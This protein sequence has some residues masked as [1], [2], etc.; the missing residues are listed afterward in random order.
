MPKLARQECFIDWKNSEAKTVLLKDLHEGVLPLEEHDVS[1]EDAW[2]TCYVN[3]PEFANVNFDQFKRQLK[4]HRKQVKEKKQGADSQEAALLHDRLLYPEK[5]HYTIGRRIF[6]M[7]PAAP[8]LQADVQN[9]HHHQLT[10]SALKAS[11]PEYGEWE[12]KIFT[13]RIYQAERRVK[14]INYL[15]WKRQ[16][17]VDANRKDDDSAED[18][19]VKK[20]KHT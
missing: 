13:Q 15:E 4:A 17:K 3:L 16:Q 11:R 20:V 1:A 9:G 8:L 2:N 10:P 19:A 14:F 7:S 18:A 6:R 5:S 12:L